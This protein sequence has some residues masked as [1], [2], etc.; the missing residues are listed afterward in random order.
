MSNNI[1]H[2][3][4]IF[5]IVKLLQPQSYLEL[6]LYVGETFDRICTIVSKC[7]G[8]DIKDV[9]ENKGHGHF[10]QMTTDEFFSVN[11]DT[12]DVIFIDADH[13]YESVYT[14]LKSSLEIL[15]HSGT[16]F[17]HDTD[18]I[19]KSY[20][21]SGYC[22]DAYKILDDVHDLDL[23]AVTFP[24]AEEGVTVIRRKKDRRVLTCP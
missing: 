2:P 16:I 20:Y 3:D 7:V 21:D 22:G 1:R 14:D 8:V 13:R 12:F 9:R 10:Y 23:D 11:R 15:N 18:P 17:L 4:F 6:G 24:I 19:D 5:D